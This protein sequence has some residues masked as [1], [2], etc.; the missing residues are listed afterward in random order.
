MNLA[1]TFLL[2]LMFSF[3][4]WLIEEVYTYA[5]E[6][7]ITNRGF[8]LGPICPI[9]GVG[10]LLIVF[11]LEKYNNDILV[12][13]VMSTIL[14]ALLEYITSYL[15]EKIFKVRWWDYSN[16]RYNING[17][18]CLSASVIF[19]FL[20]V[21]TVYLLKPGLSALL[22]LLPKMVI[23]ILAI[24]L[25]L[26][27][28]TDIIIS[29][30]VISKINKVD[31]SGARDVTDEITNRVRKTLTKHSFFTRRLANAFPNFKV[32]LKKLKK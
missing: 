19:G 8:L 18:I 30:N 17:R 2:F 23:I 14:G 16:N 3:L 32:K 15:M 27:F 22:Y 10:A 9:Y 28:I 24:V 13:F 5:D 4:G 20:G 12:L 1:V 6:G 31:L 25:A 7:K 29:G 11:L 26:V 21:I